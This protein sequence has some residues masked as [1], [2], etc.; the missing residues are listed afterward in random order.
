MLSS[1]KIRNSHDL[2]VSASIKIAIS[3][4]STMAPTPNGRR[5]AQN[6]HLDLPIAKTRGIGSFRPRNSLS[7]IK[8]FYGKRTNQ[9]QAIP[10]NPTA[11]DCRISRMGSTPTQKSI[12]SFSSALNPPSDHFFKFLE[13]RGLTG[14]DVQTRHLLP[15]GLSVS[16]E[17]IE[18]RD[19]NNPMQMHHTHGFASRRIPSIPGPGSQIDK[20]DIGID[21][22]MTSTWTT[23][24]ISRTGS[25]WLE[26][27]RKAQIRNPGVK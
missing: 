5:N 11:S 15:G 17:N 4:R 6:R 22:V 20:I 1:N 8:N 2:S 21:E 27:R 7:A 10:F 16:N 24:N 25:G 13:T 14:G 19:P 23:G 3:S 9:C 26:Q 12:I 18:F